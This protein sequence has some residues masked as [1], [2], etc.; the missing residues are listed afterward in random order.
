M[1]HITGS[2]ILSLIFPPICLLAGLSAS[3][4]VVL[5]SLTFIFEYYKYLNP[6]DS[7]N[8]LSNNIPIILFLLW[9]T[10]SCL[11]SP[12]PEQAV[13]LSL[14]I[15][16]LYILTTFA[17]Q[18]L[19]SSLYNP[20]LNIDKS[21]P[22]NFNDKSQETTL[23]ILS[24]GFFIATAIYWCEVYSDGF[25]FKLYCKA[26]PKTDNAFHFVLYKLDRGC[27]I[28]SLLSWIVIGYMLSSKRK[29]LALAVY[30]STLYLLFT[31]D[32]LASLVAY[33]CSFICFILIYFTKGKLLPVIKFALFIGAIVFVFIMYNIC[34]E[35]ILTDIPKLPD[36]AK[37]RIYI[38]NYVAKFFTEHK[39]LGFGL[40]SS[41]YISN[42]FA[43]YILYN[44]ATWSFL[45]L[46]PHNNILQI[47]LELGIIG[48]I[49]AF[50]VI[51]NIF[52]N[53]DNIGNPSLQAISIALFMQYF[54]IGMISYGI[55]QLWWIA[56]ASIIYIY[57]S[58]LSTRKF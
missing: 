2:L 4:F 20:H 34:P 9:G 22:K 8:Q 32:S 43:D 15:I 23:K 27:A 37:H 13:A 18:S 12:I 36:S 54:V 52:R 14:K 31:S 55:W 21:L 26:F 46:H 53:I 28:L 42:T 25:F 56:T 41:R 35:Q 57:W 39:I 51:N 44:E 7:K 45:P 38:W 17:V 10:M 58:I 48:L 40:E 19:Y 1:K 5:L 29:I 24:F 6:Q 30:L 16:S 47:L 11:W 49:I 3:I 50:W 33:V